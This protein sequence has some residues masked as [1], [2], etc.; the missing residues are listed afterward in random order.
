MSEWSEHEQIH[1]S[2]EQKTT[3]DWAFVQIIKFMHEKGLV[4]MF[5]KRFNFLVIDCNENV[6]ELKDNN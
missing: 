6:I 5:N 3:L 2:N 4:T 1:I